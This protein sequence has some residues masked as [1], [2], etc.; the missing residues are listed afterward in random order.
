MLYFMAMGYSYPLITTSCTWKKQKKL[1]LVDPSMLKMFLARRNHLHPSA[2]YLWQNY[3]LIKRF[4]HL[5]WVFILY[6]FHRDSYFNLYA[7]TLGWFFSQESLT[8]P[9]TLPTN[10]SNCHTYFH[11]KTITLRDLNHLWYLFNNQ[12]IAWEFIHSFIRLQFR[13]PMLNGL[14]ES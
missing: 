10:K 7:Y 14:G 12:S 9:R 13:I 11:L 6:L 1:L 8:L 3:W 4:P 5:R 2:T